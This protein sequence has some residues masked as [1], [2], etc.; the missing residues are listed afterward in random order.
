MKARKPRTLTGRVAQRLREAVI[1]TMD[2]TRTNEMA[3]M[4]TDLENVYMLV[5]AQAAQQGLAPTD[6]DNDQGTDAFYAI[7]LTVADRE[8]VRVTAEWRRVVISARVRVRWPSREWF[9]L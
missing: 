2:L 3:R 9:G 4:S 5:C 1:G 7:F 6:F 8:L